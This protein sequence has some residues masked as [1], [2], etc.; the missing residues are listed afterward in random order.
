MDVIITVY[1]A[2]DNF[3]ILR[4]NKSANNAN[5]KDYQWAKKMN[6]QN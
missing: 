1:D 6:I 4:N 2:K 5:N 3:Y